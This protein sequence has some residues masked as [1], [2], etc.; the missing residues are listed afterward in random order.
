MA[1][2]AIQ[3]GVVV[4]SILILVQPA[5][6]NALVSF[7]F[8]GIVP[9]TDIILPFWVMG[10]FYIVSSIALVTYLT[11]QPLYIGDMKHQ[12]KVA[13]Q[14]ARKKVTEQAAARLAPEKDTTAR[15]RTA[16]S[17]TKA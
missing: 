15:Y 9:A 11:Y 7:F 4:V 14:L 8:L 1:Q 6:I 5:V 2:R 17:T 3:L 13:R 10:V 12:E 16:T